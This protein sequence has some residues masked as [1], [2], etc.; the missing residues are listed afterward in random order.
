MFII[1]YNDHTSFYLIAI[2]FF[3]YKKMLFKL[4]CISNVRI[5]RMRIEIKTVVG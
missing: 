2:I 3:N 4:F 1:K 5:D